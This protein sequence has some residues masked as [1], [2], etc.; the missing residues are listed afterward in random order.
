MKSLSLR[1]LAKISMKLWSVE[2]V[3]EAQGH[4]YSDL[5]VLGAR[6]CEVS[7]AVVLSVKHRCTSTSKILRA[8]ETND[9]VVDLETWTI[10]GTTKQ[11]EQGQCYL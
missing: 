7:M 9:G 2:K 1:N 3:G 6:R 4:L 11:T 8:T 10:T 5:A